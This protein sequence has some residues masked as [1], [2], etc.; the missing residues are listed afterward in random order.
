MTQ[1]NSSLRIL[2]AG[3]WRYFF[4][5]NACAQALA[6]R[7]V[8]VMPF[9]WHS[10]FTCF[11]GRVEENLLI[12]GPRTRKL[13]RDLHTKVKR[14]QP[15]VTILWR[16][17]HILPRTLDAIRSDSSTI[18]ISYN[19]DDPFS[20]VYASSPVLNQRRVWRYFRP[21]V[22]K[23]DAH[24]VYRHR[25][26]SDFRLA[27]A[28]RTYLLRSYYIPHIHRRVPLSPSE[29][30]TYACDVVFVGHFEPSRLQYV[31]ALIEVGVKVRVFGSADSWT[32][33]RLGS[34]FDVI[35]PVRPA[36]DDDY[37]RA[38]SGARMALC[39]FSRLNRDTYTRR[40]FEITA[41]GT[42]L[43]CERTPDMVSLFPEDEAA[44]YFSDPEELSEKV[45]ALLQEPARLDSIALEGQRRCIQ[46]RHS[47]DDRM[48]D[49]LEIIRELK[50]GA[51]TADAW[52]LST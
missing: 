18:L 14:W 40:V 35:G 15:H 5:E 13:N 32:R 27:G 24:L 37:A 7:G 29:L 43:V 34:L 50:A 28:R 51:K 10:Y 20:P 46:G 36:L 9:Q 12:T 16:A 8:Q 6:K 11:V 3:D 42:L 23:Y 44:V 47:V 33:K 2:L 45:L 39:A 22:P 4:Y 21:C 26:L 41:S 25:N 17:T 52:Q 31:K 38:L 30:A 19:N 49:L 1:K 48:A